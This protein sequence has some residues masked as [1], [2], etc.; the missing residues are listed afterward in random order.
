MK[1]CMVGD[2]SP[3]LD[4]GLKN[5]AYHLSESLSKH[6]PVTKLNI[7][8]FCTRHFWSG[9]AKSD[10]DIIHYVPG[11]TIKSFLLVKALYVWSGARTVMSAPQPVLPSVFGRL[12]PLLRPDLVL[13]QS[14]E[15]EAKFRGLGCKTAFLPNGVDIERFRPVSSA[16][17]RQLREK[18]GIESDKFVVL[19]VGPLTRR[20]N[21][22]FMGRIQ[23]VDTR[24]VAVGS[25][26]QRLDR[27]LYE[28][29][30]E[31][32]CLVLDSYCEHIEEIYALADCYVFPVRKG[33]TILCP[34]SVMEAMSCNLPVISTKFEGLASLFKEGDGLVFAEKE[35]DFLQALDA[36]KNAPEGI[37]TR[38][39][40]ASY[41]W[42][43]IVARLD[44]IY[45][46][47]VS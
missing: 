47:L 13:T 17:K 3:N 24:V 22:Q 12:V 38:E 26:Y 8:E 36:L 10:P 5:I 1:I 35:Q 23:S 41:S 46:E 20:R 39:K 16:V 37:R 27:Q 42:A 29:L 43:N 28:Q 18:H 25:R 45:E 2:Y 30:N 33:N 15:S 32:G 19:H 40:V 21:L 9:F 44:G 4:E 14:S 31:V 6:H 34:L 7:K 11:P